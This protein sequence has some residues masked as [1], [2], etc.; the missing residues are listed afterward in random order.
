MRKSRKFISM[1]V[2]SL[3]DGQQIGQVRGLVIN[4]ATKSVSALLVDQ[5]KWFKEQKI[6]PFLKIRSIG[7]DAI[8]IEKNSNIQRPANLPEMVSLLKEKVDLVG[9]KVIAEN[10]TTLGFVDDYYI[11][12]SSG[13]IV[14]LEISG[15]FIDSLLKG[16][17]HLSMEHIR[18]IGRKVL[19]AA[20]GA[21]NY[22]EPL[23]GGIQE[24]L[25]SLKETS[26]QLLETTWEKT[27]DLSKNISR[28][29]E[30]DDHFREIG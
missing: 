16:K 21:E 19:V 7:D 2:I 4:P 12:T 30:K 6:I 20:E 25:R 9:A 22:L 27:V 26:A 11:E 18:T 10:G 5:K 3:E 15:N 14:N 8:T 29:L 24:T 17:A 13:Q 23:E 28:K 1:S